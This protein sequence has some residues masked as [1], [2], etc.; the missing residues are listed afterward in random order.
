MTYIDT[1]GGFYSVQSGRISGLRSHRFSVRHTG[2]CPV[3]AQ[4]I[5]QLFRNKSFNYVCYCV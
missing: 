4:E 1:T 5:A 3:T 2:T